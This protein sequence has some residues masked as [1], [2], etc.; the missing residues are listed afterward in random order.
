MMTMTTRTATV[1]GDFIVMCRVSGG[2][3]GTRQAPL[4][5]D[6]AVQ[7]FETETEAKAVA[8][9][10]MAPKPSDIYRTAFYQYWAERA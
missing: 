9:E 7:Y 3:A 6:G 2:A 1:A 8:E 4:K 5:R 10:L